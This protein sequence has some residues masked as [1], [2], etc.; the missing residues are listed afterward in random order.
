[1]VWLL[2]GIVALVVYMAYEFLH[3]AGVL[4]KDLLAFAESFYLGSW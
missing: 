3:T 1:M 4:Y 2:C